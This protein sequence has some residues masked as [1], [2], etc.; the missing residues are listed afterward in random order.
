MNKTTDWPF[1]VWF[2]SVSA[3]AGVLFAFWFS[4]TSTYRLVHE[5]L[6]GAWNNILLPQFRDPG[7]FEF[8]F[9]AKRFDGEGVLQ[10]KAGVSDGAIVYSDASGP[11]AYLIN[12]RGELLHHWHVPFRTV[13][14]EPAHIEFP[15]PDNQ[16]IF[17]KALLQHGGALL[18]LF[19]APG[20]WP[21]A[22]GLAKI[23]RDSEVLWTYAQ[24]A[25]HD[26]LL[27]PDGD[28]ITLL[29]ETRPLPIE[30]LDDYAG[31]TIIDDVI[32]VLDHTGREKKRVSIIDAILNSRY[33]GLL[34]ADGQSKDALHTNSVDWVTSAVASALP[35]LKTGQ[36]LVSM[37]AKSALGVVD[38]ERGELVWAHRGGWR[39][40][41]AAR[42][43]G[44]RRIGLFDNEGHIGEGG[45]SRIVE[46]D[47]LTGAQLWSFGGHADLEIESRWRGSYQAFDNGNRL[48]T[49]SDAGRL[50]ELSKD[51]EVVWEYVAPSEVEDKSP[52]VFWARRYSWNELKALNFAPS[53]SN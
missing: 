48:I 49:E 32:V 53:Q 41:H 51:N 52:A 16:V 23:N 43:L 27:T 26:V 5:G 17:R 34:Y 4:G 1:L 37:K 9:K 21:Y 47:A 7:N 40:Q 35:M 50:L 3:A 44:G 19:E 46:F 15:V 2:A 30:G 6:A 22:Y 10:A 38:L 24:Q 33:P 39:Q 8:Y 11:T 45:Y 31:H 29:H 20:H 12:N 36:I 14:P 18:V 42:F 13:W 28:I 25:H